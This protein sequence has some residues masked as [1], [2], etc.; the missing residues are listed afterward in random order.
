MAGKAMKP[1]TLTSS[2]IAAL[3]LTHPARAAMA[4]EDRCISCAQSYSYTCS[5]NWGQCMKRCEGVTTV[6]KQGCR[7]RCTAA[8]SGCHERAVSTCG[9]CRPEKF[10]HPPHWRIE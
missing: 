6:D 4:S 2:L 9:D 7:Q 3:L 5:D 10:P 1:L 8:R